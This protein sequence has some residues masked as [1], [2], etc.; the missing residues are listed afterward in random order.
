MTNP[1]K[2]NDW[3]F[4]HQLVNDRMTD[5]QFDECSI[6]IKELKIVEQIYLWRTKR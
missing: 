5:G 6:S 4:I 2:E 3:I 1:T